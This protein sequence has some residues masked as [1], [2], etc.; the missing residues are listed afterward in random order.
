MEMRDHVPKAL[1]HGKKGAKQQRIAAALKE[2]EAQRR[3]LE[4]AAVEGRGEEVALQAAAET[5]LRKISGERVLDDARRLRKAQKQMRQKKAKS[6]EAWAGG[7]YTDLKKQKKE[8]EKAL[9]RQERK[10]ANKQKRE[11]QRGD[12]GPDSEL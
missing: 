12:D 11:A 3:R 4:E 6:R 5:A 7:S 8:R 9:A 1:R 2:I 10:E